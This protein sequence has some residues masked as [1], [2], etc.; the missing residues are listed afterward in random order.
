MLGAR[1]ASLRVG[2]ISCLGLLNLM[3]MRERRLCMYIRR[4]RMNWWII[5]IAW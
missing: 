3:T 2:E 4:N 1:N 5:F